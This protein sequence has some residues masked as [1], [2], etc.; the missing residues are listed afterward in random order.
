MRRP[1]RRSS[2]G[3]TLIELIIV[4]AILFVACL[5]ILPRLFWFVDRAKLRGAANATKMMIQQARLAAMKGTGQGRVVFDY[6]KGE[7]YAFVDTN[8]NGTYE[9]GTDR[10][11]GDYVLNEVGK[12]TV[13][14]FMSHDD[15]APKLTG[16]IQGFDDPPYGGTCGGN[17]C[18]VFDQSGTT[19]AGAVRF[20]DGYWNFIEV[21]ITSAATG[22][23]E[24][25]KYDRTRNAY[26]PDA[27]HSGASNNYR[28]FWEWYE[29]RDPRVA[30]P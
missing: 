25:R 29:D 5:M 1:I 20:T 10:Q 30:M 16:A 15:T 27:L 23:T 19:Q 14:Q 26:I 22:K 11:L 9:A 17:G 18:I 13:V 8:A 21:R 12:K 28:A 7:V 3:F 24:L 2:S 4:L 6:A